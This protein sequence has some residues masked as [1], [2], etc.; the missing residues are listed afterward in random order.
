[1]TMTKEEQASLELLNKGATLQEAVELLPELTP[2]QLAQ[3][4]EN[5]DWIQTPES[6]ESSTT[7]PAKT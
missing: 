3:L 1:M 5:G 4:D 2:E 7:E 6:Q